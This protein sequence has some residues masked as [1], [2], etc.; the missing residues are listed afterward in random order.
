MMSNKR[1]FLITVIIV[2]VLV[3]PVYIYYYPQI[4]YSG[5]DRII[6][7]KGVNPSGI[8][9][10]TLY[11]SP[12]LASPSANPNLIAGTNRDTLYTVGV[13]DLSAETEILHVPDM[14]DRYYSIGLVDSRG[15]VFADFGTSGK[16][17]G[18]YLISGPGWQGQVPEGMTQIV[19]PDNS[20]LLIGRVL[21]YNDSD[22]ITAYE[23][24]KQ[25]NL[26]PLK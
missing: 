22:V 26:T 1:L 14:G 21:V 20:V 19:S 15:D 24:S 7:G 11:T 3:T 23:L 10:N 18:N 5:L 2:C 13:L 16:S 4:L 12:T 9:I 8:P 6:M 25:I 17:A